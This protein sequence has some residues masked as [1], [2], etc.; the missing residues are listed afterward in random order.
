LFLILYGIA[1]F[2]FSKITV[3]SEADAN[4][5][6]V[7]IYI[8]TNGVHTD[9]VVP[10]KNEVKDWTKVVKL[11]KTKSKDTTMAYV[12]FG[13]GDKGFYL[14]TPQWS[15]LKYST[16]FNAAFGLGDSA[17]H[18]T[19]FRT[20]NEDRDCIRIEISK[21]NYQKLIDYIEDSFLMDSNQDPI[22][23]SATTYGLN[24]SFYEAKGRY[25]LFHTCN[26][27]AN[28]ALKSAN[29]KAA[30]WTV[31]DTGIFCHYQ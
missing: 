28:S 23:I 9:I 3:N 17:I 15:D 19:F 21:A 12:A 30:L 1:A 27:W 25:S 24:D 31:T 20:I 18:A 26:T 10:L 13:W 8:K 14:N 2:S 6:E 29:L 16:A 5:K 22:F 7:T 11:E 4:E